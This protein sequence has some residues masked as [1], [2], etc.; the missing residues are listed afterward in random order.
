MENVTEII[1]KA[2][3]FDRVEEPRDWKN[4]E[5]IRFTDLYLKGCGKQSE[6]D[7]K[8]DVE[9]YQ[10]LLALDRRLGESPPEQLYKCLK[11]TTRSDIIKA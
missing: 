3:D 7:K 11:F 5:N 2:I 8:F 4:N 9:V 1:L 10:K 6:S